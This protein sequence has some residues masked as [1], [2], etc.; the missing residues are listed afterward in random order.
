MILLPAIPRK[1]NAYHN[2]LEDF[3][4]L[5]RL[6]QKVHL[7]IPD[8]PVCPPLSFPGGGVL[9]QKYSI[10]HTRQGAWANESM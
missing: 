9:Y 10:L 1:G 5:Q 2:P 8:L 6:Y 7:Q 4:I 3:P